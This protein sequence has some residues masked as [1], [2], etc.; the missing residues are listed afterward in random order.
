MLEK[1][2]TNDSATEMGKIL[3]CARNDEHCIDPM[4]LIVIFVP[5]MLA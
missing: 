2:Q 3:R 5:L 4:F 1:T